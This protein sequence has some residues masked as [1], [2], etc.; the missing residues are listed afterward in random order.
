M[1]AGRILRRAAIGAAAALIAAG[2]LSA[3][4]LATSSDPALPSFETTRANHAA[5][6]AALLDRHGEVIHR[7]RV[8]SSGRRLAWT[9]LE[10]ISPVVKN[11]ILAAED[12]R[13]HRHGG[14]DWAALAGAALNRFSSDSLR[15]A[16]TI[17]MQL[18][19]KLDRSL[20]PS[21]P[22]RSLAQKWRQMRSARALVRRW[23][24]DQILEAY[25]NLVTF[26][27][28]LEGIASASSGLFSKKPHGLDS[29]EA[30]VLA[31]L[32]RAPNAPPRQA[33]RRAAALAAAMKLD[34]EPSRVEEAAVETLSRPYRIVPEAALAPHVARILLG[35]GEKGDAASTLDGSLQRAASQL[36]HRHLESVR[37]QNVH[38]G[39]LLVV[40]N[41]S[42][43]V[44]AYLGNDGATSSAPFVDGVR[45]PRQA[46]STLKPFLYG[47]VFDRRLLTPA[48]LLDDSPIDIPVQGG[49][50]R[51][52]NYDNRFQGIVTVRT[53]LA[54]SLNVPAV[55]TLGLVGVDRFLEILRALGFS[56]MRDPE[57]YGPSLALGSADVTLWDMV[58]AYRTVARGGLHGPL[59]LARGG[60]RDEARRVLS[61]QAAFLV[62]DILSDREGR[63]RT[64]SLES[65]LSTRFWTAVKTGTSKEMRDNWCVGF[66]QLYTA[67]VW[68]GNF[69]G[70]PMWNVSGVTGAAPLWVELMEWLHG[71]VPSRP[72]EPP[73][74][75][76]EERVASG[77]S[78]QGREEYF[79][80]GAE[81]VTMAP[82]AT[83]T[84][85]RIAC[86]AAGTVIALDPDIPQDDQKVLFEAEPAAPD[87]A[88]LLDGTPLG[89]PGAAQL[90]APARGKHRLA[91]LD[92]K[93]KI[94]DQVEFEVRG[95]ARRPD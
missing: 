95:G 91:L 26:R 28:E 48:T 34:V 58:N 61:P 30:V 21:G 86:P 92:N 43:D 65:P 74:G 82:P 14:V 73:P 75:V 66:S 94:L 84:N 60:A 55:R 80:R 35:Q 79:V 83:R 32:V 17:P 7:L 18:A 9:R 24:K 36:L 37:A 62:S 15:G 52:R 68:T 25:L 51:P 10:D 54:S 45:A 50:Y 70:A 1:R 16:S 2:A 13:F 49:L 87:L 11:A 6:E 57:Y 12:R 81:T 78:L 46:G 19:A 33:A 20:Q 23:T 44:L 27:G 22:R 42:G 8:D 77:G 39:A 90:W 5:S 3:W 40:E 88:W 4:I 93:G 85:F 38:D 29:S 72:P 71:D 41:A 31:A 89:P 76:A 59:R 53:A 67:G 47:L 63:S 69:S 64:F 56:G